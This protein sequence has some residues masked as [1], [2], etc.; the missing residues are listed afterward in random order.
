MFFISPLGPIYPA[1]NF[2]LDF[3]PISA[4]LTSL[5]TCEPLVAVAVV[6]AVAAF[7][8]VQLRAVQGAWEV[9]YNHICLKQ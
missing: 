5:L 4:L 9:L 1:T 7:M 3:R 6:V 8:S 2:R